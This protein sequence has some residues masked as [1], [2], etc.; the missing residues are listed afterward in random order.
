MR[1]DCLSIFPGIIADALKHSIPGRAQANGLLQIHHHDLRTWATDKHSKVDD[2]PY[3]GGVGMVFKPEPAMA[4]IRE[5]RAQGE[6]L[7]IH[8]SPAAPRLTQADVIELSGHRHLIFLAS[9]YEGLDQ[10][11]IDRCVDREYSIGD[12]VISGGELA[13]AVMIDAV[14]RMV[15]GVVAKQASVVEDSFYNGLL[16][17]PHYTRPPVYEDMDV[18]AV[19]QSGNHEHIRRWRKREALARTL[20]HRPDLLEGAELDGEARTMLRELGWKPPRD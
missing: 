19:L 5:L 8:P 17:Y 12:Y 7:V 14:A 15:P 10:R 20:A 1:I 9:R 13:C 3:G 16:D 11:V 18:P 2:I 6:A 4:A